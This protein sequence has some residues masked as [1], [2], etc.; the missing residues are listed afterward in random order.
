VLFEEIK[1][2]VA[3]IFTRRA[4]ARDIQPIDKVA[5]IKSRT[6]KGK[7]LLSPSTIGVD[8][9]TPSTIKRSILPPELSKT[10]QIIPQM[11]LKRRI[12]YKVFAVDFDLFFSVIWTPI[13]LY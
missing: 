12:C 2:P 1:F 10:G 8:Y 6:I 11:V 3:V 7:S 5:E 4:S 13:L 9:L